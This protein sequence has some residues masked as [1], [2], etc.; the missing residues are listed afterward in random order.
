[1]GFRIGESEDEAVSDCTALRVPIEK[2]DRLPTECREL[3]GRKI[4]IV[5]LGSLGSKVAV[6][7]GRSGAKNF[8]LV[9]DDVLFPQNVCRNALDWNEVGLLKVA[10]VEERLHALGLG[11]NIT[12]VQ[13]QIGGQESTV[14]AAATLAKLAACDVIIDATANPNCF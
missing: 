8:V 10:G 13:Q 9:D 14:S 11:M 3:G 4:G 1:L 6:M 5:G 2:T 12:T 7:L